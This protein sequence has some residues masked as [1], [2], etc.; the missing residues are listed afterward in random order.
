MR[1]RGESSGSGLP[2]RVHHGLDI[3]ICLGEH[4]EHRRPRP[5]RRSPHQHRPVPRGRP[6]RGH[7][8]LPRTRRQP[9]SHTRHRPPT[10]SR[11]TTPTAGCGGRTSSARRAMSRSS[12]FSS[13]RTSC[14]RTARPLAEE[15]TGAGTKCSPAGNPRASIHPRR[16]HRLPRGTVGAPTPPV[17]F[18][19]P[20]V[21]YECL[22]LS[23]WNPAG[24]IVHAVFFDP[25]DLRAV[26]EQLDDWYI[27]ELSP[28][29]AAAGAAIASLRAV[30]GTR[31]WNGRRAPFH[32]PYARHR[33]TAQ[34]RDLDH[35]GIIASLEAIT[36][37][38]ETALLATNEPTSPGRTPCG[39][40]PPPVHR[41]SR[42]CDG[43]HLEALQRMDPA[44]GLIAHVENFEPEQER[45]S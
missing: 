29:D 13:Q 23:R 6:R 27:E 34:F 8:P 31:T 38:M 12:P 2:D 43:Q 41:R 20:D 35:D 22:Y 28:I 7:G 15:S 33:S 1:A 4:G 25:D 14:P 11:G 16:D 5:A 37:S 42:Q 30:L 19:M 18:P 36:S 21:E 40:H 39:A 44:T 3:R 32:R 24:Q 26:F 45:S 9:T 17:A 10:T